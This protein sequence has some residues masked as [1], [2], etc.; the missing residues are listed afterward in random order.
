MNVILLKI[1]NNNVAKIVYE[2]MDGRTNKQINMGFE[3]I[4]YQ[5]LPIFII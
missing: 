2:W 5:Y 4:I 1:N 3:N